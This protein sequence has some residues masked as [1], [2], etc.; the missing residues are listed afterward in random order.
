MKKSITH[1]YICDDS[2][3]YVEYI[4]KVILKSGLTKEEV[5]FYEFYAGEELVD[6]LNKKEV[7]CDL[8]I[9]D[10]QLP[11]INGDETAALFR[12]KFADSVLV[13]C[14]GVC[15]PTDQSFKVMAYRYLYK[16]YEEEM[17]ITEMKEIIQKVKSNKM[18]DTIVAHCRFEKF[19]LKP[20]DIMYI[21]TG[22]HGCKIHVCPNVELKVDGNILCNEKLS[23]LY[24]MLKKAGFEYA[25][26]SY[27]VNLN[28]V[29]QINTNTLVFVS[30]EKEAISLSVSRSKSK[31]IR[32]RFAELMAEKYD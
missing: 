8:L 12:K 5:N 19:R 21:E 13:F 23:V 17:M 24:E 27:I 30:W 25:H 15:K 32:R 7:S 4:K 2:R 20:R 18:G 1:I 26:N 31:E 9:L 16:N 10:M 29:K 11:G 22:K 14:S 3:E 6:F 28:Y